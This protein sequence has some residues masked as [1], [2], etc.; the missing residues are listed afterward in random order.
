MTQNLEWNTFACQPWTLFTV[1]IKL[2]FSLNR[3][4]CCVHTS[5][6]AAHSRPTQ[7]HPLWWS[8]D[9]WMPDLACC[10]PQQR[11][12]PGSLPA[13]PWFPRNSAWCCQMMRLTLWHKLTGRHGMWQC[14]GASLL[15]TACHQPCPG[16][17]PEVDWT[18]C[19]S[20]VLGVMP[21]YFFFQST[22]IQILIYLLEHV[23]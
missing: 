8:H 14:W 3:S 9:V 7:R 21:E 18:Q 17:Q 13:A 20:T 16:Y 6:W 19:Y 10:Q 5:V 1:H 15:G 4:R 11:E 22:A 2:A 12:Y 23:S